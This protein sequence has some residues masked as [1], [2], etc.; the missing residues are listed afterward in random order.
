VP[1]T[2]VEPQITDAEATTF[3]DAVGNRAVDGDI[4]LRVDDS[5]VTVEPDVFA[6]ALTTQVI[7]SDLRLAVD[8]QRLYA[9]SRPILASL[10]SA[11]VD[12]TIRFGR[13]RPVV[14]P[15]RRGATVSKQ[16]WADAVLAAVSSNKR[17]ASVT[18]TT[19][20]PAFTTADARRLRVRTR[21]A[22]GSSRLPSA[23]A[24]ANL[25][26]AA[27]QLD[28]TLL[29][30][31]ETLSLLARVDVQG[32]KR[33]ASVVAGATY[34]AAFRAGLTV[35]QRTPVVY[36]T[37]GYPEGLG[38]RVAPPGHDLVVRN[39]SPYGVY[40]SASTRRSTG[41]DGLV[42][43]NLWSSPY[44]QVKVHASHR[45]SVV[46]PRTRVVSK[47]PCFPRPGITGFDIDLTR[48]F[49]RS[50]KRVDSDVTSTSYAPRAGIRCG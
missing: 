37:G 46:K 45:H 13:N 24:T 42:E 44:W 35:L 12:A 11:P 32:N 5:T 31:G 50:G 6:S 28:G 30:P 4:S 38:A 33:A 18:T 29:K 25:T 14:V 8:A 41:G 7:D 43:V 36:Y 22:T 27:R 21:V 3:A 40:V 20:A 47:R 16:N 2:K 39:D 48:V 23:I 1:V 19:A 10:A 9:R 34:T 17:R 26:R 15:G 49:W